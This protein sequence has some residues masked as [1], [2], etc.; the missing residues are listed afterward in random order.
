MEKKVLDVKKI[1]SFIPHRYPFLLV[2]RVIDYEKD[3]WITAIKN[4][5][6]NES[7]FQGHF[8]GEPIMPGVLQIEALAQVGGILA[9]M[10]DDESDT[11]EKLAFFM[12]INNAKFRKPVVPGDQLTMKVEIVKRVRKNIVQTHGKVLVDDTVTCEADLMFSI[13]DKK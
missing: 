2:D 7:F 3:K 12:T 1:M 11:S 6:I 13:F 10:S 5:T 8:P 9:L 4:V